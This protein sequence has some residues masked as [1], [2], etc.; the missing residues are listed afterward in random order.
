MPYIGRGPAKSGAFRILDDVSG[1][2]N[3]STTSFALTVGS[4][5]LTVGLPETLLI[6]VD[7]VIQEA[8]S[9]Y[10][11]SGSNI[12]FTA[13]PQADATFWGVELGDVGGLADRAT[14]QSASDNSTKVAT[15]AYVD[16]QVATEDTIA[17]M[18]DVTL[19]SI[20]SGEVLKWNGSAWINNTL[21]EL[22]VLPVANP[23]FTG[24]LTVGSAAI[25]EAELEILDGA[26][27]TTTEL[28]LLDALDRGSILYGN[29]SGVTTVLGQGGADTVLTSDGTDISWA[30]AAGGSITALSGNAENRI[31]AFG[32]TT[33]VLDGDADFTWDG[34][35][36]LVGNGTASTKIT[37]GASFDMDGNADTVMEWRST[38][39][40]THGMTGILDTNTFGAVQFVSGANSPNAGGLHFIGVSHA[41]AG[42]KSGIGLTAV[43][44]SGQGDNSHTLGQSGSPSG[45]LLIQA[46]QVSG[47]S[48]AALD[49]GENMIV[50]RNHTTTKYILD[51]DGN[52]YQTGNV[53]I[54]TAGKGIDFAAQTA[55]TSGTVPSG[56]EVLDHYEEG[57]FT[58]HLF[59]DD[60][61][62]STATYGYRPANYT[63]I[64]NRVWF[65]ISW[66]WSSMGNL[67]TGDNV[68]IGGLPFTSSSNPTVNIRHACSIG[69][70]GSLSIGVSNAAWFQVRVDGNRSD[71]DV[72]Y[73]TYG[74]TS[75]NQQYI[76]LSDLS[77]SGVLDISGSY[78]VA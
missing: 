59:D 43:M 31:P 66:E 58:P 8:G 12:V 1:S 6:A 69:M 9:A 68:K 78:E 18:G 40:I 55:S 48:W 72:T 44:R 46:R 10:T 16:A 71:A 2:F 67:T 20:G 3:G 28:N 47:T 74:G 34:N 33:T 73:T 35:K 41:N 32:S 63:R 23:T 51:A 29:A 70:I 56:G 13:A 4:A 24:T 26:T 53:V 37:K 5:A 60:R 65:S 76:K 7:G 38:G 15:T 42:D 77:S 64:G 45:A 25:T 14:T 52:T 11:I 17:E 22:G 27:V 54:G 57:T 62:V 49:A 75:F 19:S 50:V 21:A 30:A 39:R 61:D 36:L